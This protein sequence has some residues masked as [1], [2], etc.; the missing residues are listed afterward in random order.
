MRAMWHKTK[1]TN[2]NIVSLLSALPVCC[3]HD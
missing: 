2:G 3:L 1:T